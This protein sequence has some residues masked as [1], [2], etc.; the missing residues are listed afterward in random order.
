MVKF[1]KT[2]SEENNGDFHK[3]CKRVRLR[4]GAEFL[5]LSFTTSHPTPNII[6]TFTQF[7]VIIRCMKTPN[8]IT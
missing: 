3:K 2:N 5:L 1:Y 7:G 4:N 8:G 6:F